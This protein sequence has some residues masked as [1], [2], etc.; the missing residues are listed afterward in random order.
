[1]AYYDDP[2][3]IQHLEESLTNTQRELHDERMENRYLNE[4][5]DEAYEAADADRE[6]R[7]REFNELQ[8]QITVLRCERDLATQTAREAYAALIVVE[9]ERDLYLHRVTQVSN[10]RD[11]AIRALENHDE[12]IN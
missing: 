4:K 11:A 10:Q 2:P 3:I 6:T 8:R 1:M 12:E 9:D 7:L 5:L